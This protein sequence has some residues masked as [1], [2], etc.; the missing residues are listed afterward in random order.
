MVLMLSRSDLEQVLSMGD[1]IDSLEEAF[2]ELALGKVFIIPRSIVVLPK[3][4]G[5]IGIMP[6]YGM[7]SFSTKIVTLYT[8][9]FERNL[10]TIMGTIVLNDPV[11]G[12]VLA[13]MDG[14][15]ITG[16]RTGGLG[17]LAAKYLSRK[18]S[19]TVG[20][21]GAGTQAKTQLVALKEVRNIS[22]AMVYDSVRERAKSYV[23]EMS[24]KLDLQIKIADEPRDILRAS[25]IVVTVSTSKT[26]LFD[27]KEIRPGTHINAFGN[28]KPDERELDTE[29]ILKSRVFVDYEEAALSE[30][31]DLIIPINEGKF[32]RD[33]IIG[34]LGEVLLGSKPGRT[35]AKEI[36]L[37]KSVGLGIQDCAAASLAYRNAVRKKIGINVDLN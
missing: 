13:I 14:T 15:F 3:E 9:N 36:T 27:G 25:D 24:K 6:A 31:G 16:M 21:F 37:F 4:E 1:M 34:N 12:A 33:E 2:K 28:Y 29:T 11:T 26:P 35:S 19:S 30:A 5:W 32:R 23:D 17:G 7:N 18:D 8:K 10:P 22:D 20:I